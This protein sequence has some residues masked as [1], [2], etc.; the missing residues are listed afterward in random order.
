MDPSIVL[1]IV[2][3]LEGFAELGRQAEA[4]AVRLR[5]SAV[6]ADAGFGRRSSENSG[7][8]PENP[9]GRFGSQATDEASNAET[10]GEVRDGQVAHPPVGPPPGNVARPLPFPDDTPNPPPMG[11]S[12][13][14]R[15]DS[16]ARLHQERMELP[17]EPALPNSPRWRDGVLSAGN[18][19]QRSEAANLLN[20]LANNK[21]ALPPPPKSSPVSPRV[22]EAPPPRATV[23]VHHRVER[24]PESVA[25]VLGDVLSA[26][27]AA[28]QG[29]VEE[30]ARARVNSVLSLQTLWRRES[31]YAV[32]EVPGLEYAF[33]LPA[34]GSPSETMSYI[35][36]FFHI[37]RTLPPG[38]PPVYHTAAAV[39]KSNL[40]FPPTPG[41]LTM[42]RMSLPA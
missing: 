9:F 33:V 23:A 24:T 18:G 26:V 17:A 21:G 34:I 14:P 27:L 19:M 12:E 22:N 2:A 30:A 40:Q 5:R 8:P 20:S 35:E 10:G 36:T 1:E 32:I 15:S 28:G 25:E 29:Y 4:L 7:T 6:S 39:P 16:E 41:T 3:F 38:S 11:R 31:R 37:E 42:G 13:R